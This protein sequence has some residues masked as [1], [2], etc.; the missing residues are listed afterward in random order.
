MRKTSPLG[1]PTWQLPLYNRT[2]P[3]QGECEGRPTPSIQAAKLEETTLEQDQEF[4][5]QLQSAYE[6]DPTYQKALELARAGPREG[7]DHEWT[8][9]EVLVERPMM[10][11][12]FTGFD[13]D[14]YVEKRKRHH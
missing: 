11:L 3:R 7:Q 1:R 12:T 5:Q 2:P 6:T 13:K 8:L 10:G 14:I 9:S 4:V